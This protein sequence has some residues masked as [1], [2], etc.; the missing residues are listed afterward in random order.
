VADATPLVWSWW[1]SQLIA[2][3][4]AVAETQP[5]NPRAY[6]DRPYVGV[7]V[8]IFRGDQVL[9][10][11]RGRPPREIFWSIPGGAQELDE[12]VREAGL[13]E[14]KEETGLEVEILGLIDVVDS[15]SRD[16]DGR[17]EYHYTLVDFFA[18]WRSGEA[19]AGDDCPAVCWADLDDLDRYDL[20][21]VTLEIIYL[22][23]KK[24]R[25][26]HAIGPDSIK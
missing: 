4:K 8:V 1:T 11:Q 6:P 5:Q 15:I 18:E 14:V 10:A 17:V 13:R 22:A 20:R 12:T 25:D 9:L 16:P 7:G 26:L 3:V 23:E 19:V 21:A 24:R 2:E